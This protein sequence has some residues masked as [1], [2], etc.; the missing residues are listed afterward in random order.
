MKVS[1][2]SDSACTFKKNNNHS[3]DIEHYIYLND[4]SEYKKRPYAI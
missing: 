3:M 4:M 2:I 1:L